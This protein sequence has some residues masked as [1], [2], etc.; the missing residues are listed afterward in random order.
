MEHRRSYIKNGLWLYFLQFFNVITPFLLVPYVVRTIGA[1]QYGIFSFA[2]NIIGYFQVFVEYGFNLSGAHQVSIAASNNEING[3]YSRIVSSKFF[4]LITSIILYI[5]TV[6]FT[7]KTGASRTVAIIMFLVVA[8][9][10]FQQTWLFQ[11]LQRMNVISVIGIATRLATLLGVLLMVKDPD[12]L[13]LYSL[14][15]AIPFFSGGIA[16]TIMASR[17]LG[18]KYTCAKFN[19]IKGE[20]KSGWH[21]FTTAA[22][23][24]LFTGIGLTVLA[25]LNTPENVGIYAGI[26]KLPLLLSSAF[27]PVSQVLFP[28]MSKSFYKDSVRALRMLWKI[29]LVVLGILSIVAL[30]LILFSK[31][32]THIVL[33]AEYSPYHTLLLPLSIWLLVSVVNNF[34]GIQILVASGR[35]KEYSHA[36]NLGVIAIVLLTLIFGYFGGLNGV[37]SATAAGEGVLTLLLVIKIWQI[38]RK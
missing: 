21:L 1:H 14:L 35:A 12:D 30:V 24:K 10:A 37:A 17:I 2:L 25:L 26:Q 8:G 36:F 20:L 18:I 32:I 5:V 7:H 38:Y 22:M 19:D 27:L 3:L 15:Y 4:L 31:E 23:T 6:F 9:A 33:G 34:L 16:S 29:A 28:Y 11:G 13:V